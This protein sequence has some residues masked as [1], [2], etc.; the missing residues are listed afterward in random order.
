M[1]RRARLDDQHLPL[2]ALYDAECEICQAAVSW[3]EALDRRGAVCCVAV[4]HGPVEAV[5][6][7]LS[8]QECLAQLHVVDAN[9][10]VAR[11]WPAVVRL[12]R[13]L[14]W[15]RPLAALDHLAWT[16]RAAGRSYAY[17][18][19]NRHQLSTCRGGACPPGGA[20]WRTA[21]AP[22]WTCY[23]LG[24]ALRLPLVAGVAARDQARYLRDYARTRRR[25]IE[26]LDQRLD[27]WFLGGWPADLV[28]LVF[29]ERFCA[30]WYR[31][32]LVDPGS[33]RMRRSLAAHLRA[34]A[35]RGQRVAA[36][37]ATHHHEEH[38]GNLE[39]A[40]RRA[41][42]PV[43][44]ADGVAG[45]L[46]PVASIP[47]ARRLVIGQPP[48]LRSPVRAANESI[49]AGTAHLEVIKAP[50]HS[51]DHVVLWDPGERALLVGDAFM[52]A[53]FSSPNPDVDSR[54][55][56]T[57]LKRL[58]DLDISIMV[59]GHGHV[60][61]LRRDIRPVPGV[62]LRQDPRAEIARKLEFLTWLRA[63]IAEARAEGRSD[64]AAVASCFPW[65]RRWS[66][67]RLAADEVAR[68]GTAGEFSRHELV[69]S[70]YRT[71]GELLPNVLEATF[72]AKHT[73]P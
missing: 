4:Q 57:T 45:R 72:T 9:G 12:A 42:A 62:V 22:F 15:T 53:Y 18:A 46:R 36:V 48:S 56:I 11:G 60:R 51:P 47:R 27:L 59:E 64:N 70:F 23:S 19:R 73:A 13:V 69:R 67:E 52:G 31:G 21:A 37:T 1:D 26:L 63:R 33:V 49:P 8:A 28:P 39:W 3:I 14:P 30:V 2:T 17:I 41:A 44:L 29:G 38:V 24:L 7:A 16:R 40:A 55:W 35:S 20:D 54:A 32:L 6:P 10:G 43:M 5:H 58:L 61:T 50:G 68:A 65:G 66:W 34:A 25:R 71:P